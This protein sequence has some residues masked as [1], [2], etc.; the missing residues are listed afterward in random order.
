M[1]CITCCCA[2]QLVWVPSRA[3]LTTNLMYMCCAHAQHGNV[4]YRKRDSAENK[5][6]IRGRATKYKLQS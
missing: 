1:Y 6:Q 2:T 5:L 3:Y 4:Q